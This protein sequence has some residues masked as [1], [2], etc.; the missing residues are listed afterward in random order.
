[1]QQFKFS[2]VCSKHAAQR[3][4][5]RETLSLIFDLSVE[6]QSHLTLMHTVSNVDNRTQP[7]QLMLNAKPRTDTVCDNNLVSPLIAISCSTVSLTHT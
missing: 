3:R 5:D 6:Q 7:G 2:Q 4:G 1:V